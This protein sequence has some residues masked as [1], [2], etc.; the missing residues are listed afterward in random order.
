MI[1]ES[2]DTSESQL[3]VDSSSLSTEQILNEIAKTVNREKNKREKSKSSNKEGAFLLDEDC[4]IDK[5]NES[6][7]PPMPKDL[8]TLKCLIQNVVRDEI[9][10]LKLTD[11]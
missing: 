9:K 3:R 6:F 8:A 4:L 2:K 5:G 10:R 1:K 11:L 7:V